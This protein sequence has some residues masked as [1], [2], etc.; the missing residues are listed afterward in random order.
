MV[1]LTVICNKNAWSATEQL[2]IILNSVD[3]SAAVCD[4]WSIVL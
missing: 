2:Q 3:S 4:G 1:Q